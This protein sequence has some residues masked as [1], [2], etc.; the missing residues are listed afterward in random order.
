VGNAD[1]SVWTNLMKPVAAPH[2][3]GKPADGYFNYKNERDEKVIAAVQQIPGTTWKVAVEFSEETIVES[4]SRFLHWI[5]IVG[6]VFIAI[7]IVLTWIMS[8]NIIRPLNELTAS[9]MAIASGEHTSLVKSNHMDELG[10]LVNAFNIMAEKIQVTQTDLE[11]KVRDRTIKLE[12][13]KN[14][15]ESFSYSVSHDLRAPLRGVIG[16]TS[17]LEEDY[18]ANLDDEAR[19]ICSQIKKNTIKMG[20]LIDDLLAF[21]RLGRSNLVKTD[22]ETNRMVKEVIGS[23]DAGSNIVWNIHSLPDIKGDANTIRQVWINLISNAIKYSQNRERPTIEIGS[24]TSNDNITFFVKD[25][26]VGFDQQYAGKLF[27][28]FQRLHSAEEFEGTGIG[29]AIVEK[30]ISKH[31]GTVWVTAE[32]DKGATFYFKLPA[33]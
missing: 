6:T 24:T 12:T 25:N 4:A 20:N 8:R 30:I 22:I 26:G 11:N 5:F 7:G 31:G 27:K 19:R 18:A 32:L 29:L 9:A 1:G 33:E 15:M 14:E 10:K 2:V 16:Y 28:V 21:S 13:A 17:I 23:M 3:E